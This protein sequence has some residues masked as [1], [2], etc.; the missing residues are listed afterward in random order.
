MTALNN[1]EIALLDI[2]YEP[3]DIPRSCYEK[4]VERGASLERWLRRNSSS[5]ACYDPDVYPQGSFRYGT[6]IRPIGDND[7]FDLDLVCCVDMKKTS[8]SQQTLKQLVGDEIKAYE[9]SHRFNE[10]AEEKR[11]CWRLNYTDDISFHID[12]LPSLPEDSTTIEAIIEQLVPPS[13]AAHAISIT[14]KCHPAFERR[15]Q[16]WLNSNSRGIAK[17]F[18]DRC[19]VHAEQRISQLVENRIYASV[20]EVPAYDW[21]TPLQKS[22][23]ILKRHRDSMFIDKRELAPI[24]MIITTLAAHA[25]GGDE[26]LYSS[27]TG[28]LDRMPDY[29]R[30]DPPRVPNP[31][32]PNEDFA[33]RWIEKPSLELWFHA[34]IKQAKADL[35][36]IVTSRLQDELADAY[37]SGFSVTPNSQQLE[38]LSSKLDG[39]RRPPAIIINSAPKPWMK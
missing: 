10:P 12:V 21:K 8:I 26:D 15:T 25:Y 31:T 16:F 23:Q 28:I 3:L 29:V 35:E 2:L 33:E 7:E 20:D 37:A 6:V 38:S 22:I 4:A 39:E 17:W 9:E 19:R 14:D 30:D 13:L 34:W 24:S 1:R 18:E 32:N 5:V 36:R 11:R 27:L